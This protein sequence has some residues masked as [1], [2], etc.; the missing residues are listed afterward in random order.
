MPPPMIPTPQS[1]SVRAIGYDASA[2]ELFVTYVGSG[3]Y[4]YLAVPPSVWDGLR[5][6]PSKGRFVNARVK[7]V[8]AYRR[9]TGG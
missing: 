1:S 4:A 5:A 2:R 3:A 7:G 6:A 8:Y 9:L